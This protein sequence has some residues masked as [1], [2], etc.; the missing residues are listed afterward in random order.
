[1]IVLHVGGQILVCK[2]NFKHLNFANN[3]SG[4]RCWDIRLLAQRDRESTH[5]PFLLN[6]CSKGKRRFYIYLLSQ[7]PLKLKVF[8][9]YFLLFSMSV[10]QIPSYTLRVFLMFP[11]LQIV[12][13]SS[14]RPLVEFILS[15]LHKAESFFQ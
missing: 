4:D 15:C 8:P 12:A 13:Y 10:L 6:Q 9:F 14:S 3:D 5:L 2:Q 1:M 7:Q 11:P